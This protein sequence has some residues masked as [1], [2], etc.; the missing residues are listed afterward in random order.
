MSP[1][2]KF[3][4][5]P[6]L[7]EPEPT[8]FELNT[9]ME[10]PAFVEIQEVPESYFDRRHEVMDEAAAKPDEALKP[11]VPLTEVLA[12]YEVKQPLNQPNMVIQKIQNPRL[13]NTNAQQIRIKHMLFGVIPGIF[14]AAIIIMLL[15]K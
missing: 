8:R 5:E 15:H 11:M 2:S 7:P 12:K 3:E 14:I 6:Q 10:L 1:A 4:A 13:E 9:G